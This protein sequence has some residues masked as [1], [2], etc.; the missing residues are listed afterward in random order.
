MCGVFSLIVVF[1]R[2]CL[3]SS[4]VILGICAGCGLPI[5]IPTRTTVALMAPSDFGL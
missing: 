4:L 2:I 1:N 3:H 5:G